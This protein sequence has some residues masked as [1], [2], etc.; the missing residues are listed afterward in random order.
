MR[1][2]EIDWQERYNKAIIEIKAYR[3]IIDYCKKHIDNKHKLKNA[4][5]TD[6]EFITGAN[7]WN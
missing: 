1:S 6:I 4:L 2:E 7:Q 3:Q 5:N